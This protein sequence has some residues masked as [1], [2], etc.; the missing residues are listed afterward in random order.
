LDTVCCE[1]LS[2]TCSFPKSMLYN[3]CA[4]LQ[5]YFLPTD[6]IGTVTLL[7]KLP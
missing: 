1:F 7:G 5:A 4:L 2:F 6:R 3:C